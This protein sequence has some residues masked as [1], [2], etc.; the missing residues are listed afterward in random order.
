[1][2][3]STHLS[4]RRRKENLFSEN[5]IKIILT[6]T[7]IVDIYHGSD[8]NQKQNTKFIITKYKQ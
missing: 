2:G 7:K 6:P 3:W 8:P 1:M 4:L 5:K